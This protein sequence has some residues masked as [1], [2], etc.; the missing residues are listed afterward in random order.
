[1][2]FISHS[3][4]RTGAPIVL[5]N[6]LRW[7]KANSALS[8]E[9]LVRED[10]VLRAEFESIAPTQVLA[11]ASTDSYI[12]KLAQRLGMQR[13]PTDEDLLDKLTT[14]YRGK[15]IDLVYA[16]TITLG[17][18]LEA[19]SQLHCPVV[20]H[21]HE[22]AHWIEKCGQGNLAR[23]RKYSHQYVAASRAVASYLVGNLGFSPEDISV[24]HEFVPVAEI[25]QRAVDSQ[26]IRASLRI[27]NHA[28]VVAG[29]GFETWRK[30]KDLFVELAKEVTRRC[31]DIACFFL[32]VGG[33]E[34][35]KT[36]R[37]INRQIHHCGLSD[38]VFFVGEVDNPLDYFAASDVFAM[39]SREDPFPL[40]CLEAAALGK[41]VLCFADAG[42]MPEFVE[43]D[44]GYIV[45][46]LDVVEMADRILQLAKDP[47]LNK[48]LGKCA[49]QKVRARHDVEVGAKAILAVV[50]KLTAHEQSMTPAR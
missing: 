9:V 14:A 3:A 2:L 18:E 47:E 22:L 21:V 49:H 1:M 34:S 43:D 19:L 29:S 24:V 7:L 37:N 33:W 20:T 26:Q 44:A 11:K 16:N 42:G 23:V 41:P 50:H 46:N 31:P 15:G 32:W 6:A 10:G 5:L 12:G 39:V 40:V 27:P 45:K 4:G 38:R 35:S 8:F 36:E 28:F 13:G 48:N 17:R 30:G 25:E